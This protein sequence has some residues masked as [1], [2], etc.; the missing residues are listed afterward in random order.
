MPST[1]GWE[2]LAGTGSRVPGTPAVACCPPVLLLAASIGRVACPPLRRTAT[3]P[4][5]CS[6][7]SFRA[8]HRAW[9]HCCGCNRSANQPPTVGQSAPGPG[10]RS[11]QPALL[12]MPSALGWSR[13]QGRV[14]KPS[15]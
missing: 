7:P 10:V 5:F 8:P 15:S 14:A 3:Q 13:P 2:P 6:A 1:E 11:P 4:S 9:R 12:Y